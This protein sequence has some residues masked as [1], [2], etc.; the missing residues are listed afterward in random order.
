MSLSCQ[1]TGLKVLYIGMGVENF[2]SEG[3][4]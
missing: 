4:Q 1:Q 3:N 2:F